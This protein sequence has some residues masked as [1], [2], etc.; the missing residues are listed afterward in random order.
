VTLAKHTPFASALP[1]PR[2]HTSAASVSP[3]TEPDTNT[4]Y[5]ADREK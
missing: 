2:P 4:M 1:F 3:A 5:N